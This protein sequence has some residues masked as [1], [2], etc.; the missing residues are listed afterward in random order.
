MADIVVIGAGFSGLTAALRLHQSGHRV[1][2]LEA[3]ERVGGRVHSL[4]L[5]N[6]AI[7][8]MGGEWLK[9]DQEH[10]IGLA[11]ELGVAMA[12]TDVDFAMRD[13]VGSPPISVAEHRRVAAILNGALGEVTDEQRSTMSA[14]E[15]IDSV[16]DGSEAM[17]VVRSRIEG[18]S[19]VSLDTVGIDYLDSDYGFVDDE[20]VRVSDGNQALAEAI[21]VRLE[22]IRFGSV[23]RSIRVA[24]GVVVGTGDETIQ[25]DVAVVS[26]PLPLI[27]KIHFDPPLSPPLLTAIEAMQMGTAAKIAVAT[28]TAPPRFARHSNRATAWWWTGNGQDGSTRPAVTGFAGTQA[29][30][31]ELAPDWMDEL[32][33]TVPEVTFI[34]SAETLDWGEEQWSGGCYS[35]LGPGQ[36]D[37]LGAFDVVGPVVW[38]GEHTRAG[39]SIDGA[40]ASG[41]RAAALVNEYVASRENVVTTE[42]LTP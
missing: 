1:T 20:Y 2:V 26:V 6:G 8:E 14:A 34:G 41:E 40:I 23:A 37:V 28:A 4:K 24:D 42:G 19:A 33:S 13:L 18:S 17:A 36:D 38:A 15:F 5:S 12:D 21:A 31:D 9:V 35:A 3:R 39:G 29:A 11:G 16:D 7:V 32:R 10:V 22:D 30:I 25:A 27:T